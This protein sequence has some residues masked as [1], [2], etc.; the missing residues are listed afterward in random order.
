LWIGE[1]K[2]APTLGTANETK[3]KLRGLKRV[4]EVLRPHGVLLVTGATV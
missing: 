1:A 4:A 2:I 3:A